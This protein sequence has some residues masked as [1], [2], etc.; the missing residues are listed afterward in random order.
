MMCLHFHL[1][2]ELSGALAKRLTHAK[3]QH[4]VP[5]NFFNQFDLPGRTKAVNGKST[6]RLMIW[7]NS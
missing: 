7:N 3:N 2:S 5:Y 6:H 4:S 1:R